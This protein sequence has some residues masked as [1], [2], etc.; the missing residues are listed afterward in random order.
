MV[1]GICT[2]ICKDRSSVPEIWARTHR[3]TQTDRQTDH[4]ALLPYRGGVTNAQTRHPAVNLNTT[5]TNLEKE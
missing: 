3:H 5:S 2:K 4:N 1:T